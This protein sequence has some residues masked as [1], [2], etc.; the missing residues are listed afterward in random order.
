MPVGLATGDIM[1]SSS[2]AVPGAAPV[3]TNV[4]LPLAK[5]VVTY[6]L[7]AAIA[8]VFIAE[9]LL[10]GS[11]NLDTLQKLGA[12]VNPLVAQGAYWRLLASMFLHIGLM[13]IG[14]NGWALF[15]LG[16]EVE[17]FYG[18][19]RFTVIYFI[20]GI[21]G[22]LT[23]YL[24]GSNVLSAG[25]SGA[26]FGLVGA[27]I[28]YFLRNRPLFGSLGRQRLANLAILVGINLVFGFTMPGINNMAHLGGLLSGLV[29]GLAVTPHYK[30]TW[31]WTGVAPT[32][33][34]VNRTSI[35]AQTL[36]VVTAVALLLGGVW[37]G[38]QRWNDNAAVLRSRAEKAIDAQNLPQAQ[39]LLEQAVTADPHD[40]QS[41]YELGVVYAQQGDLTKSVEALETVLKLI[42]GQVDTEYVLGLV[43]VDLGRSADARATLERFL[44]QE[45]QG[46]RA[47][48]ARQVLATLP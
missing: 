44:A 32:P 16:R 42:P 4:R 40:P 43:Y 7:L 31:Q 19:I 14:F 29:L 30:V 41:L 33:R 36:A 5:P 28:A 22:S 18:S 23:Y 21:F 12:Q 38:N 24:L 6:V 39:V 3:R 26:I 17:A 15:I 34:L 27:E 46:Q 13:H 11:T 9:T 25:A 2:S 35:W 37:L 10:G 47:D 8:V 20:T 1:T 48:H 45:A